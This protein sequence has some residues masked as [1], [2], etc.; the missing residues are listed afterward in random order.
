MENCSGI[1]IIIIML[2][3]CSPTLTVSH[4]SQ[5]QDSHERADENML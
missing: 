3:L 5:S 4:E 2:K 1:I